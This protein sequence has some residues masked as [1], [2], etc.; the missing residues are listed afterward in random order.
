LN[1]YWIIPFILMLLAIAVL[2]LAVHEWWD[3][4]INKF[5][6]SVVLGLPVFVYLSLVFPQGGHLL[7][8]SGVEYFSFIM[9]LTALYVISGGIYLAGD[10]A[11]RPLTNVGFLLAGSIFASFMGTTGAAM[12]LIRPLLHTNQERKHVVHTV[13]FFIFLVANIGGCMTPLGDPPLFMGYL[14]G[15]PFSWTFSL[16]KEWALVTGLLLGLYWLVDGYYYRKEEPSARE[17]DACEV[18][19]LRLQGGFNVA[20][21]AGVVLTIA[22]ITATPQR[23]VV[24]AALAG[25]S[26]FCTPRSIHHNNRFNFHPIIEVAVLFLGIFVTMVPAIYL[27]RT[28]GAEL[29]I[30]EPWQFFW[31]TGLLS[32]FLDNTPTYVVFFNLA[33]TLP[34]VDEIA[35]M[36]QRVLT[37]VSLGAVFFGASTYIGNAPN[38]MVKAI[39]EKRGV[40][41]PSFFGYLAWSAAVLF[42]V[43]GL[44]TLIWFS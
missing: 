44:V 17:R 4:N 27:L 9:L 1:I 36:S 3:R 11:A 30:T 23:E 8:H 21:L 43:F 40:P 10:L 14:F 16:W 12:M 2:P 5:I 24:L 29:G 32:S 20:L 22:F 38:F 31:A 42:P 18:S 39:A 7:I 34:G 33:Q 37:A 6:V 25:I 26:W 13:V 41:M 28:R 19:A 35:G 15:V